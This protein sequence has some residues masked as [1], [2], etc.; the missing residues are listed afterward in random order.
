[1]T[2]DPGGTCVARKSLTRS[3]DR[4]SH[5]VHINTFLARNVLIWTEWEAR[6]PDRVR[7]FLATHVPPGSKVIGD[8][9]Y[10]F[11]ARAIGA[12]FQTTA[13]GGTLDERVAF[14][15]SQFR[16]DFLVTERSERSSFVQAYAT[17]L[18]LEKVDTVPRAE[19]GPMSGWITAIA[20]KVGFVPDYGYT[21]TLYARRR[22]NSEARKD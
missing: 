20:A 2:L 9:K 5:S 13:R 19:P 21:G 17:A 18:D 11:A 10:Y 14:H 22:A 4:A 16:A 8:D 7:D 1:M 3:G 6:S 12:Q 15:N